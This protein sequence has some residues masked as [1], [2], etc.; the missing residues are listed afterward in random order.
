MIED[1]LPVV[2]PLVVL[3]PVCLAVPGEPV[4]EPVVDPVVAPDFV[5]ESFAVFTVFE[6]D[7]LPV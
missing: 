1:F 2:P 6:V 7:G 5:L 3:L 4:V